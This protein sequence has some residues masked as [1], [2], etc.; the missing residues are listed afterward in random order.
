M[1][2]TLIGVG[3]LVIK[4]AAHSCRYHIDIDH[5]RGKT[6]GAGFLIGASDV[7]R[8]AQDASR[9]ILRLEDGRSCP[10]VVTSYHSGNADAAIALNGNLSE[11]DA[12][13]RRTASGSQ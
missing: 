8:S 13:V 6:S 2:Q 1:T 12:L 11:N 7:L 9:C 10:I 3:G 5:R 4:G